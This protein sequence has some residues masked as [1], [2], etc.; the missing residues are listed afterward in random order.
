MTFLNCTK[1]K[2]LSRRTTTILTVV[3]PPS[4]CLM[5]HD[6]GALSLSLYY[7]LHLATQKLN[8]THTVSRG[9]LCS[10]AWPI[11]WFASVWAFA[12]WA[13]E[14]LSGFVLGKQTRGLSTP[15]HFLCSSW[16]RNTPPP[17]S[18][19]EVEPCWQ[20]NISWMDL[21]RASYLWC[22]SKWFYFLTCQTLNGCSRKHV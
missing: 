1:R 3:P 21:N 4:P 15:R 14:I 13:V 22:A 17:S 9:A 12:V 16:C 18:L 7:T 8:D 20:L 6:G 11:M 5:K 10:S 19:K 2:I